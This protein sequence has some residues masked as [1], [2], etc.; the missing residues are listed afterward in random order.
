M[1]KLSTFIHNNFKS[2]DMKDIELA[3]RRR[4]IEEIDENLQ[5]KNQR[6]R[7]GQGDELEKK[8]YLDVKE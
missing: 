5:I 6:Q 4:E 7:Q 3:R 2:P 1:R 8:E